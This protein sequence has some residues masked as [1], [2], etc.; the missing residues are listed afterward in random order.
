MATRAMRLDLSRR[1][2]DSETSRRAYAR[3]LWGS[4]KRCR[5]WWISIRSFALD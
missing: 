5:P 3:R 4:R 1:S 2:A